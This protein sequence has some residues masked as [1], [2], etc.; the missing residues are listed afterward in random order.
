MSNVSVS[1][2]ALEG[3]CEGF[4][5]LISVVIKSSILCDNTPYL[6]GTCTV[7]MEVICPYETSVDLQL[8]AHR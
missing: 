1:G 8:T 5:V 4:G 7:K 3:H 6:V 2:L